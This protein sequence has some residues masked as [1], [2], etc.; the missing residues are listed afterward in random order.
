MSDIGVK[1]IRPLLEECKAHGAWAA[2]HVKGDLSAIFEFAVVRGLAE[3]NPVPNLRGLLRIPV[4]ESQAAVTRKQIQGFYQAL[5]GY[6]GYLTPHFA[7][8]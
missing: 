3:S 8:A 4:S 5:R 2:I 7:C 1:Q 6:R